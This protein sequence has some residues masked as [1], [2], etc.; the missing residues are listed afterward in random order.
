MIQLLLDSGANPINALYYACVYNLLDVATFLLES[1]SR[2]IN[3][4]DLYLGR[5]LLATALAQK[6]QPLVQLL[7]DYGAD[8]NKQDA[9][10]KTCL[11]ECLSAQSMD[12]VNLCLER[13]ANP[14]ILDDSSTSVLHLAARYGMTDAIK[15]MSAP[16]LLDIIN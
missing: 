14:F 9:L 7:L 15:I 13:G 2:S 1:C 5:T 12:L 3:L 6:N 10:G 11:F 16:P 4:N 8:I